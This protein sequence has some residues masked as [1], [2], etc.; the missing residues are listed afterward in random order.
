M[1]N[2]RRPPLRPHTRPQRQRGLSL[3]ELMISLLVGLI[4]MGAVLDT[5]LG[6]AAAERDALNAAKLNMELRGALDVMTD[7]IRRAG[8]RGRSTD[9]DINNDPNPFVA[10]TGTPFTDLA[11]K[12]SGTC[13]EFAYDANDN[14]LLDAATEL[15]GFRIQSDTAGTRV[16][17]RTGGTNMDAATCSA[18]G[19]TWEDLTDPALV[20]IEL[21]TGITPYFV[22][23]YQCLNSRTNAVAAGLCETGNAVFDAASAATAVDLLEQR[24]VTIN[25]AGELLQ[26][27][28][29]MRM[30][31]PNHTVAV[32]NSRIVTVGT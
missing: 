13:I 23:S 25:L 19:T 1:L 3:T 24:A 32:R 26:G 31:L 21:P 17:V 8:Y 10:R 27:D 15:Y 29:G 18:T 28:S 7:D 5:Y 2:H 14:G 9:P 16:Q 4:I 30:E 20:Q 12:D 22:A 6:I 11:I